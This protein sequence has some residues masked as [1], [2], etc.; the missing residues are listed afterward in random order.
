MDYE[1][2]TSIEDRLLNRLPSPDTF[3][4]LNLNL[5]ATNDD[6]FNAQQQQQYASHHDQARPLATSANRGQSCLTSLNSP[7]QQA[8][9][10]NHGHS[11]LYSHNIAPP[12]ATI[13]NH[14]RSTPHPYPANGRSEYSEYFG[15]QAH[16]AQHEQ[17]PRLQRQLDQAVR[18]RAP[19]QQLSGNAMSLNC[20]FPLFEFPAG[21]LKVETQQVLGANERSRP[22]EQRDV[23]SVLFAQMRNLNM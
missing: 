12:P 9:S 8:A 10:G 23:A 20:N 4:G 5:S 17:Q 3:L 19:F 6:I 1:E 16:Q 18:A 21:N 7:Q 11:S 14:G 13:A 2:L 22:K 15:N